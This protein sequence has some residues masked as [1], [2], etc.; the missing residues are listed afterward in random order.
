MLPFTYSYTTHPYLLSPKYSFTHPS[1][2]S[3]MSLKNGCIAVPWWTEWSL[4]IRSLILLVFEDLLGDALISHQAQ[5]GKQLNPIWRRNSEVSGMWVHHWCLFHQDIGGR[6]EHATEW[7]LRVTQGEAWYRSSWQ[8]SR[9]PDHHWG[10]GL[11]WRG[12]LAVLLATCHVLSLFISSSWTRASVLECS[13]GWGPHMCVSSLTM[14]VTSLSQPGLELRLFWLELWS[15]PWILFSLL[16]TS[17][18]GS[19]SQKSSS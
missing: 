10:W 15:S 18:W 6:E 19:C 14:F 11:G 2:L 3:S 1:T 4:F 9:Q 17:L 12:S 13:D 8:G 5:E 16:L 7:S